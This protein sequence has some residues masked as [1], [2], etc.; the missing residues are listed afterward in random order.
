MHYCGRDYTRAVSS[1]VSPN[2]SIFQIQQSR[3]QVLPWGEGTWCKVKT[4]W[5][6][7]YPPAES[8]S[9]AP[10]PG[11]RAPWVAAVYGS[12]LRSLVPPW[13]AWTE[14]PNTKPWPGQA[15]P[16]VHIWRVNQKTGHML[17][18]KMTDSCLVFICSFGYL[19]GLK[20]ARI[21][22]STC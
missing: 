19:K 7:L 1:S 8:H 21:S 17:A 16:I 11:S 22:P 3:Q 15:L 9:C 6:H 5:G 10:A 20:E 18:L 4:H 13:E 14:V 2:S 12:V